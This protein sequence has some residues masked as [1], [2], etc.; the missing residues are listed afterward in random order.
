VNDKLILFELAESKGG[1]SCS[2]ALN[3]C[4]QIINNILSIAGN[5]NVSNHVWKKIFDF[6]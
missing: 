5:V 4:E 6:N 2:S 1:E 3:R